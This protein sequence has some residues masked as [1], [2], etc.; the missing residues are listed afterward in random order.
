MRVLLASFLLLLS[1]Q[2]MATTD[3]DILKD[4]LRGPT[5]GAHQGG[6]ATLKPNTLEAFQEALDN[7]ATVIEM[8]LHLSKDNIVVVFHNDTL[9]FVTN[10]TGPIG[11]KTFD[12]LQ[13][14]NF[15][16]R[17]DDIHIPKYEDI[18]KWSNGR[19]VVN[20]EFKEMSVIPEAL[21]LAK[22]YN[23]Y[24]WCYF[25]TQGDK[26]KYD[27]ARELDPNIALLFSPKNQADLDWALN[28]DD[29]NLIIIEVD[30]RFEDLESVANQIHASGRL[31]SMDS[32][33][34]SHSYELFGTKC[35]KVFELGID[36][37]ISN[38]PRQCLKQKQE[39]I[40]TQ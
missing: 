19:I 28:L 20:A 10:C 8:D 34:F 13:D 4:K 15:S 37:A 21:R 12:E 3:I 16:W 17:N 40:N 32:F 27:L 26:A 29:P 38:K 18:L 39:F 14:C 36:I 35:Y 25:Q 2:C 24:Q 31:S 22:Q 33:D 23:C 7:K 9:G 30:T 11:N 5:V 1:A 6:F